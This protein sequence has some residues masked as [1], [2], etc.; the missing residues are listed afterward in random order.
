MSWADLMSRPRAAPTARISYGP[1]PLQ[2]VDL[3]IPAGQGPFPVVLMVHG[4]CW[5]TSVARLSIMD[6]AAEDLRRRGIAVWNIEYRGVD[7]P[8][9]GYPGTFEDVA[10]AADALAAHAREY[11]LATDRVVAFGHSAGGH[12]A[13]W[14]AARPGLPADSPLNSAAPIPIHAAISSGGLPDL[15]AT[16]ARGDASCGAETVD[17][18]V[19]ASRRNDPYRDTSPTA[20][21]PPAAKIVVLD[22]DLDPISPPALNAAF[23]ETMAGR[24]KLARRMS[25]DGAGHVE[26]IAPGTRAWAKTAALLRA[27]LGMTAEAAP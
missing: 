27:S 16:R 20:L 21:P 15:A 7:R 17:R 22:G 6:W 26:L 19:G 5:T 23:V 25:I 2:I 4:G 24:G 11:R 13:I 1:D 18:L 9:G 14:L 12:L 10:A 3:W 8:G